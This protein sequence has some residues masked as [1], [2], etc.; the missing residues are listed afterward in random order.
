VPLQKG[1][2]V[3]HALT[4]QKKTQREKYIIT[5]KIGLENSA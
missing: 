4:Q 5:N 2:R 3:S 1:T